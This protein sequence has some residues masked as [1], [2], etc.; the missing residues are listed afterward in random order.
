[1]W[2]TVSQD[3]HHQF[4][5]SLY[6][7]NAP[8]IKR[9]AFIFLPLN[10]GPP[11]KLTWSPKHRGSNMLGPSEARSW[12]ALQL[13]P[14]KPKAHGGATYRCCRP[15][16]VLAES[17]HQLPATR[18]SPVQ[19]HWFRGRQ[20]QLL[21][22]STH[23]RDPMQELIESMGFSGHSGYSNWWSKGHIVSQQG[24]LHVGYC[25]LLTQPH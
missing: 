23:M 17:Q 6:V 16:E 11:R 25:V 5:P 12:E 1:M 8:H 14:E 18:M 24:N 21:P 2:V 20:S 19:P 7:N 13:L 22:N 3:G 10:P 4:L 15:A 9:W